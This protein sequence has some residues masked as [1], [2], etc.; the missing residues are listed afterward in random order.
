MCLTDMQVPAITSM[1]F[2]ESHKQPN[3]TVLNQNTV[4]AQRVP[5]AFALGYLW[6]CVP[7]LVHQFTEY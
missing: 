4:A 7:A 6:V 3:Y 2:S 1:H 5:N